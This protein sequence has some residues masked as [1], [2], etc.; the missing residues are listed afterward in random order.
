MPN[1]KLCLVFFKLFLIF[2]TTF[3][4]YLKSKLALLHSALPMDLIDLLWLFH[5][6]YSSSLDF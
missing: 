5:F 4:I 2:I 1:G 3:A 6:K